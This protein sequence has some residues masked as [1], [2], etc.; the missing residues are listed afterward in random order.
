MFTGVSCNIF[1]DDDHNKD[2][3]NNQKMSR[4]QSKISR[5]PSQMKRGPSILKAPNKN[6]KLFS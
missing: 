5:K 2:G 4:N 3:F 1:D 6:E